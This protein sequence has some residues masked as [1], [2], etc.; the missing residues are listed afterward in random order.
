M[1]ISQWRWEYMLKTQI[2]LERRVKRLELIM[3]NDAKNKI[4][5]LGDKEAGAAHK[6]GISAI[7]EIV[8]E[9]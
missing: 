4:A 5:S 9:L 7:E 8:H 3:L 1:W 2:D 6:E